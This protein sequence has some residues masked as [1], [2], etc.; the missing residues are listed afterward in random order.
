MSNPFFKAINTYSLI[1][2]NDKIAVALS[3]GA[4]SVSLLHMLCS[5]K[6]K[7]NLTLYAI[8]INHMIRGEEAQRDEDFCRN[9]CKKL[10]I[11]LFTKKLDV[12]SLSAKQKISVELCGR[13]VRYNEFDKLSKKLGC[14]IA[15]AHTLSDNAETLMINLARGTSLNGICG[16]P[17]KRDYIIR[18]LILC[19]RAYIESYCKQNMLDFVTDSTNLS[20]DYTRNKIRHKVITEFKGINPSF[21][22][23]VKRLCDDARMLSDYLDN[24]TEKVLTAC[25]L[26]YGYN[27]LELSKQDKIIRQNAIRKICIN[28]DAEI[29]EHI[30]IDLIDK[31]LNNSGSVDLYGNY[32][33]VVKQGI[34]RIENTNA[35]NNLKSEI[36]FRDVINK[37][38]VLCGNNHSVEEVINTDC[39]DNDVIFL[40][41]EDL[42]SAV[43]RTRRQGDKIF[44]EERKITKPLR[45]AMN[46]YKIPSELRDNLPL[47]AIDDK[48]LWCK[49]I[50]ISR[51]SY[52]YAKKRKFKFI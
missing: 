31:L 21:E 20:D 2:N 35:G 16:I 32:R 7:Y 15:T 1:E 28:S 18:P 22:V 24:Q 43:I 38:F 9:I 6:E 36:L 45:K 19:D 3:G 42:K 47:V 29:P 41:D 5:I 52:N 50:Q 4:D 49:G 8:H 39:K 44:F 10:D 23:S 34:L 27:A 48:I 51:I 13:N 33:A 11:E 40:S 37:K 25:K 17:A 26:D 30:H 12:L 14:K 46:E